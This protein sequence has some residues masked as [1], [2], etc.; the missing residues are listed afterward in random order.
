MQASV[1]YSAMNYSNS[2]KSKEQGQLHLVER[3][4]EASIRKQTQTIS[5]R[6]VTRN[7][8]VIKGGIRELVRRSAEETLNNL[9][10][11]DR[12]TQAARCTKTAASGDVPLHVR[13]LKGIRFETAITE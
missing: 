7:E 2:A 5:E 11:A 13:R 9:L 12:L 1:G 6:I 10:E 4:C 3:S 8:D